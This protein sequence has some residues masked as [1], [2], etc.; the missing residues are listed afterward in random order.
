M[1][2]ALIFLPVIPVAA[3]DVGI[4]STVAGNGTLGFSGDGGPATS[5]QFN[6]PYRVACDGRGNLYISDDQRI[7]KVDTSGIIS[8]VAGNGTKGF[9]GDGGPATAA[10]LNTPHAV[11]FDKSGNMY[12]ADYDNYC[13]RKVDTSGIISTVVGTGTSGYSGDGGPATAAQIS[14]PNALAFDSSGNM[15]LAAGCPAFAK[16]ILL[17]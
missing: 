17:E 4:I 8:T 10:Q 1:V 2:F 7:R 11:A 14:K 16:W 13:I 5:A 6:Y 9:S 15:Y 12:I 3:L